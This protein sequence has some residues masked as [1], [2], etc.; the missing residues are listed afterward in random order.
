MNIIGQRFAFGLTLRG[1]QYTTLIPP[2]GGDT[3]SPLRP[4][5]KQLHTKLHNTTRL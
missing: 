4:L 5:S 1:V 2:N 3:S